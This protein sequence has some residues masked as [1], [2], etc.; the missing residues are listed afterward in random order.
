MRILHVVEDYSYSGG[1]VRTVV[2]NLHNYLNNINVNSYILTLKAEP[3]DKVFL[4]QKTSKIWL[5][6]SKLKGKIKE[7]YSELKIDLIHIHGVW[8]YPQ[9]CA[10]NFALQNN[11]PFVLTSHGMYEPWYWSQGK[12]KKNAYFKF[13]ISKYFKKATIIHAITPNEKST[14]KSLFPNNK[15]IEIPNLINYQ[16]NN[17]N[18]LPYGNNKPYLLYLGRLHSVKG[19]D[20]LIEAFCLI[21][22]N[23][24]DLRIAGSINEYK[25]ELDKII[26]K[27]QKRNN[28]FFEGMVQG[29]KKDSLY[30]NAHVFILP[31]RA[32]AIGMVNLEAAMHKIPVITSWRTGLSPNWNKNGGVLI[33][34]NIKE[35]KTTLEEVFKWSEIDRLNNGD[36]LSKFVRSNYSWESRGNDWL[37]LY[38]KAISNQ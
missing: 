5:Y 9:Y 10:A 11:I 38:K 32:E 37:E 20:L 18:L 33:E 36:K 14:Q 21:N 2:E 3:G 24:Y 1:G 35:L 4:I 29:D 6:S 13:V 22:Q 7:I 26:S 28:I 25:V 23:K 16:E 19:I 15:I 8:M 31:S 27:Y 12:I 17:S 34:P 30:Q